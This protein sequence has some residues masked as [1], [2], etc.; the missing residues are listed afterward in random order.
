MWGVATFLLGCIAAYSR[1]W[2]YAVALITLALQQFNSMDNSRVKELP[3]DK[4]P[5]HAGP[6][7]P[8]AAFVLC[9]SLALLG[10][11]CAPARLTVAPA[12]TLRDTVVIT[13]PA[14]LDTVL[15]VLRRTDTLRIDTGR[16]RVFIRRSVDT[17]RVAA[18]CAPDTVRLPGVLR[19]ERVY[20]P[21]PAD[22]PDVPSPWPGR[23]LAFGLG[24]CAGVLLLA[25]AST[26]R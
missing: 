15:R 25:F 9:V 11:G 16:V 4:W 24:L 18:E 23:L 3:P 22:C 20:V 21:Q 8:L 19:T 17:L 5:P 12:V 1:E 10:Q 14:R 7:A 26:R 6:G 2:S 13:S